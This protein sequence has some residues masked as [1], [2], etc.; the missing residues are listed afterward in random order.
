MKFASI[1]YLA[2]V[3]AIISLAV[4]ISAC[5]N[6]QGNVAKTPIVFKPILYADGVG[7]REGSQLLITYSTDDALELTASYQYS[8]TEKRWN[9]T[10]EDNVLYA[11]E[12]K[13]IS[14]I[15]GFGQSCNP[16]TGAIYSGQ[17]L[18]ENYLS[19][20]HVL[21]DVP[22]ISPDKKTLEAVMDV[23]AVHLVLKLTGEVPQQTTITLAGEVPVTMYRHAIDGEVAF[24]A[25][26]K[27][28]HVPGITMSEDNNIGI[29]TPKS[30]FATVDY[31]NEA[32]T[33]K[34]LR[35]YYTITDNKELVRGN[36][37]YL[38]VP[39]QEA[40]DEQTTTAYVS[41]VWTNIEPESE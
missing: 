19:T 3:S 31:V 30:L 7:W 36:E 20:R 24:V 39:F 32:G 33:G 34:T 11:E 41:D 27:L 29:V 38:T 14:K 26:L 40:T 1:A 4:S 8:D 17:N 2:I 37:V 12:V 10:S 9:P 23:R 18:R 5:D 6:K 35:V 21:C 16:P 25:H 22:V 13:S 15:E 28:W